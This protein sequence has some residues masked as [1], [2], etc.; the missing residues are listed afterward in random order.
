[1]LL[2]SWDCYAHKYLF[3]TAD[4][5]AQNIIQDMGKECKTKFSMN[6]EFRNSFEGQCFAKKIMLCIFW[7]WGI[8]VEK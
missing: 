6:V 4:R 1:M 7:I 8:I 5:G 3:S 2:V